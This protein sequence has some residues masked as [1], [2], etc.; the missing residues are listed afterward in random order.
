MKPLKS[1]LVSLLSSMR[2]CFPTPLSVITSL[3]QRQWET[4]GKHSSP[5]K[6]RISLSYDKIHYIYPLLMFL[7]TNAERLR[8]RGSVSYQ[9]LP[10]ATVS[11]WW[12]GE[13]SEARNKHILPGPQ[14]SAQASTLTSPVCAPQG[15]AGLRDMAMKTRSHFPVECMDLEVIVSEDLKSKEINLISKTPIIHLPH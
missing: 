13:C 12:C 5:V 11:N 10:T 2:N 6:S 7:L 3:N 4:V 14:P 8:H 15:L 9:G 1:F